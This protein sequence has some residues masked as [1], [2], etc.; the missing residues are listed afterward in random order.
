MK[1]VKFNTA[2]AF[3][4]IYLVFTVFPI[5]VIAASNL[6]ESNFDYIRYAD[7]YSDLKEAYGYNAHE[8]YNHYIV[9]GK[10][11]GRRAYST[12]ISVSTDMQAEW[13]VSRMTNDDMSEREK[14]KAIHDWLILNCVYNITAYNSGV[15]SKSDYSP[16]GPLLY[17]TAICQGYAEAFSLMMSYAGIQCRVASGHV[18]TGG[19]HSWNE[20]FIENEWK[21]IDVC[22]D[23]PVPDTGGIYWYK[24]YLLPQ[25]V[26][27]TDHILERYY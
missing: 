1:R 15:Y 11:E 21:S 3:G 14:V 17:G 4:I 5:N 27:A 16:S 10:T 7:D 8:L 2:M 18:T 23:D 19:G 26:M 6:K 24:Y 22:W 13:V 12:N 25:E 20:V 9:F